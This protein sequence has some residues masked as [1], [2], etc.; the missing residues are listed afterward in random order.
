MYVNRVIV[1]SLSFYPFLLYLCI[2]EYSLTFEIS[3]VWYFVRLLIPY[4]S[5]ANIFLH[6]S[7]ISLKDNF[8]CN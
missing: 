8:V 1:Y 2:I 7:Q 6:T 5:A 4:N 3:S